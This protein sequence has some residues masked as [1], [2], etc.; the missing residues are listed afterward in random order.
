MQSFY[1]DEIKNI[2]KKIGNN[3]VICALSGGVDSSVTAI[4]LHKAIGNNLT[5]IFVN[6]GLLRKKEHSEVLKMFRDNYKIPLIYANES[7]L[8]LNKLKVLMQILLQNLKIRIIKPGVVL[9]VIMAK[10]VEPIY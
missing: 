5:C 3:K 4:L 6:H 1:E 8:F 2:R 9:V 7:K 10:K